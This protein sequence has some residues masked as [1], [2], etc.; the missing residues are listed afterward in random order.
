MPLPNCIR[1]I[2][3][4]SFVNCCRYSTHTPHCLTKAT[5]FASLQPLFRRSHPSNKKKTKKRK[6]TIRR[7]VYRRDRPLRKKK[8]R[9]RAAIYNESS[10]SN[11][12][13]DISKTAKKHNWGW[14]ETHRYIS[15]YGGGK[16]KKKKKEGTFLFF[17]S[18]NAFHTKQ[19][20][21]SLCPASYTW[22]RG[23]NENEKEGEKKTLK[24]RRERE[25]TGNLN[26]TSPVH[27]FTSRLPS[28]TW[29]LRKKKH[30]HWYLIYLEKK[31]KLKTRLYGEKKIQ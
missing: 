30:T 4:L 17:F 18:N 1:F 11:N 2:W 16:K 20:Q 24:S 19:R 12:N 26:T 25:K 27:W 7:D 22:R 3:L 14:K 10:V 29:K 31:K 15:S 9:E 5:V 28:Y 6:I 13:N 21:H 23:E 8:E